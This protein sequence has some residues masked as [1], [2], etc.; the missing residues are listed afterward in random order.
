MTFTFN[1]LLNAPCNVINLAKN[2]ERW[3]ISEER[4]KQAGFTN[5]ERFNAIDTDHLEENW[6]LLNNPKVAHN[7]DVYFEKYLGKQGC[8]LS[9][10]FIWKDIIEKEIPYTT[11]FEDDVLF[12]HDWNNLA[13][14]YF[15]NTPNN[16][17]IL[18]LGAQFEAVSEFHI[19]KVPVYCTHAY[20]IT[21]E[22]AKKLYNLI[23][24]N[25]D[26]VYTIDGMLL[27]LMKKGAFNW[28]VWNGQTFYPSPD[29]LNN[30]CS[31]RNNGLVYQDDAFVSDIIKDYD[32]HR[33]EIQLSIKIY[34]NF[35]DLLNAPCK[36]INLTKNTERLNIAI[37]RINEAGFK[38]IEYFNTI[39]KEH[40]KFLNNPKIASVELEGNVGKQ[41]CFLAHM[42]LW[43]DIIDKET[44]ITT[45]FEDN[46]L[47]QENWKDIAPVFFNSTPN[48]YHILYL[49]S[50]FHAEAKCDIDKIPVS[51]THAYIITYEGAKRLYNLILNCPIGVYTIDS[52]LHDLMNGNAFNWYVW[53]GHKFRTVSQWETK[54]NGLVHQDELI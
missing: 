23:L 22:G 14:A 3:K 16:Y 42:L 47:F 32:L 21:F 9:H 7:K 29:E 46:I 24:N 13:P 28:Y 11:I 2:T 33:A 27:E 34:K 8:F 54:N 26:G 5:F 30:R 19:D 48:N 49:G 18:Y 20:V 1:D 51:C 10:M 38:N 4:I 31:S 39:D 12:H 40:W 50:Q 52:M 53:N 35:N 17:D 25:T 45:I 43:K 36:L 44:P 41:E 37:E 15:K 6:K